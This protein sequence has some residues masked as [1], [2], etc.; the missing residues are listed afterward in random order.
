[1]NILR[2]DFD[3]ARARLSKI[4]GAAKD[5][6]KMQAEF[7][8]RLEANIANSGPQG[9]LDWTLDFRNMLVHRGRRFEYGQF[10]PRT[11][12]LFGADGQPLLRARRVTH[13]PRDP[14]RSDIEVFLDTPWTMVL[15]EESRRT[16]Q[17]L[18]G[19]TKSLVETAATDL[20]A[21]WRWRRNHPGSLKQPAVQWSTGRST[22]STGFNGYAP[23]SVSVEP[24]LAIV[25]PVTARRFRSAALDDR[26]RSEWDTF[27]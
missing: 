27:D 11:P 24:G 8:A 22:Q 3:R 21:L 1:M 4:T 10:L 5:G 9:W 2:A 19:S 7:A 26:V 12:S 25:H 23:G 15:S 16:H 6:E 20:I 17:G 14:S 18:I 13:L